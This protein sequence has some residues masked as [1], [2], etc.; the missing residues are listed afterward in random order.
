MDGL[1]GRGEAM[2]GREEWEEAVRAFEGAFEASG[3]SSQD[4]RVLLFW[5]F[6]EIFFCD[7]RLFDLSSFLC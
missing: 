5:S 1:V 2:L 6:E 4:V 7:I 3:K